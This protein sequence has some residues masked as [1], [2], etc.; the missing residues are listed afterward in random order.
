L[1]PRGRWSVHLDYHSLVDGTWREPQAVA[2]E[3]DRIRARWR[4][5]RTRVSASNTIVH[6]VFDQ[7]AEDL[8]ALRNWEYDEAPD[9]WF[10]MAGVPT[11]TGIF[12]RDALT[13]SWQGA[14][15]GPEMLRGALGIVAKTQAESD[16]AFHDR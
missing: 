13:A 8:V 9:V 6:G 1:S 5:R 11:Y 16:S 10:P 12:G 3:R 4:D 2:A 14:L 7:A 15:L